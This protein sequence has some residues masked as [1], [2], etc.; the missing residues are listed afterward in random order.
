MENSGTK[1][2]VM[3]LKTRGEFLK[4]RV[5]GT[6]EKPKRELEM[7]TMLQGLKKTLPAC[8]FMNLDDLD[9]ISD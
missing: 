2:D 6:S 7:Q 5:Q 9:P 4:R 1:G 8:R 3:T